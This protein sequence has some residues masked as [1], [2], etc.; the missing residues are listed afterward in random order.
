MWREDARTE[1]RLGRVQTLQSDYDQSRPVSVNGLKVTDERQ[2]LNANNPASIYVR[3]QSF[4]TEITHSFG[5]NRNY[6][7]SILPKPK[8]GR[9]CIF[10]QF[11]AETETEAE[12]RSVSSNSSSVVFCISLATKINTETWNSTWNF[13]R[14]TFF[15]FGY[16]YS[17]KAFLSGIMSEAKHTT[18]P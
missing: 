8:T 16:T 12:F 2:Q 6:C 14:H 1:C 4:S 11:G 15:S 18:D 9:I 7:H 10:H 5:R 13:S 17:I 3:F